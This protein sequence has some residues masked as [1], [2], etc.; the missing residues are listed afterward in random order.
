MADRCDYALCALSVLQGESIMSVRYEHEETIGV[1]PER[2]FTAIDDLP[3]TARWLPP[4]VLLEKVGGGPNAPGDELHYVFQQGG[5]K[6]EMEGEI[7]KR[8]PGERLHCKYIDQAFEVSVD[9][10]VAPDP[11][12]TRTTHIIEITPKT[13]MGK[14]M[15]P[16]LWLGLRKQTRD[17]AGNLKRLLEG[18]AGGSQAGGNHPGTPKRR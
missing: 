7:L 15:S 14:L 6:G 11:T 10:H 8:V 4:C 9:L 16:L 12:G 17:A 3:L 5:R 2:V 13:L 1:A 18:E